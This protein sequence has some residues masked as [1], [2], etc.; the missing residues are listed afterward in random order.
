MYGVNEN[1]GPAQPAVYLTS[2]VSVDITVQVRGNNITAE[3]KQTHFVYY[4]C[5][6]KF[7]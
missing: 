3:G 5:S 4:N 6:G 2:I 1:E 7:M